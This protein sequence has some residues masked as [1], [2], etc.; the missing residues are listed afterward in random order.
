MAQ[1]RVVMFSTVRH[2]SLFDSNVERKK[3]YQSASSWVQYT[4]T[5][6]LYCVVTVS[7]ATLSLHT[8]ESL[9]HC[10]SSPFTPCLVASHTCE[11]M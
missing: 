2:C 1:Q 11:Q 10:M 5:L 4:E 8:V 3:R 6:S 7:C 9:K